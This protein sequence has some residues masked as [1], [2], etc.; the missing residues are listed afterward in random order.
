VGRR[1]SSGR[2]RAGP[3]L[4]RPGAAARPGKV[5]SVTRRMPGPVDGPGALFGSAPRGSWCVEKAR[6]PVRSARGGQTQFLQFQGA[7]PLAEGCV[8]PE[9]YGPMSLPPLWRKLS[10]LS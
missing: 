4:P 10:A 8:L 2:N 6:R 7:R 5:A 3:D 9:Q 1:G